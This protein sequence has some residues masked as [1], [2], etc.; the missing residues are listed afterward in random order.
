MPSHTDIA[1]QFT[2]IHSGRPWHGPSLKLILSEVTP[3]MA[4]RKVD[5]AHSIWELL[6]HMN[7]WMQ[8]ALLRLDGLDAP[9]PLEGDF[10]APPD[11]TETA[12]KA[13]IRKYEATQKK[14][15][16]RLRSLTPRTFSGP[17]K[18][19]KYSVA[20]MLHGVLWHNLYHA[21][22]IAVLKRILQA[23][24]SR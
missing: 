15:Q 3:V 10:P 20:T 22:Q 7:G 11:P 14:L 9:E 6:L 16:A 8:V 4:T 5:G 24:E 2:T 18:G 13:T 23:Q 19:R 21:G 1:E 17:V 12:W